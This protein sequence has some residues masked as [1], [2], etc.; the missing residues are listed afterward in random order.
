MTSDSGS[1]NMAKTCQLRR[2]LQ[3]PST[4]TGLVDWTDGLMT[5]LVHVNSV[6][7]MLIIYHNNTN[8]SFITVYMYITIIIV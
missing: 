6:L 2:R 8:T 4:I 1:G 5:S 3:R 7:G